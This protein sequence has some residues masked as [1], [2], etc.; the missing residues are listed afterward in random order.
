MRRDSS[1]VR[2]RVPCLR[3]RLC[4]CVSAVSASYVFPPP[5]PLDLSHYLLIGPLLSCWLCPYLVFH[6]CCL[7]SCIGGMCVT[8]EVSYRYPMCDV[9]RL[10]VLLLLLS[11]CV[12]VCCKHRVDRFAVVCVVVVIFQDR[13]ACIRLL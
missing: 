3:R 11:P 2:D 12:C 13:C 5:F 6:F 7:Y 1:C 9:A 4:V 8:S 10:C